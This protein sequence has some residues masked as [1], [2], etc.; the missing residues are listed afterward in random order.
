MHNKIKYILICIGTLVIIGIAFGSNI[1]KEELFQQLIEQKTLFLNYIQTNAPL[2]YILLFFLVIIFVLTPVPLAAIG[3]IIGGA[4]FGVVYG[5]LFNI[6]AT[7]IGCSIGYAIGKYLIPE[8]FYQQYRTK[9]KTI[10]N[11]FQNN[12]FLYLMILR[13]SIV[14]PFFL[15]NLIA[16]PSKKIS[17][18]SYFLST[19][20]SI[21][22]TSIIYAYGGDKIAT[23]TS[24]NQIITFETLLFLF[25]IIVFLFLIIFVQKL[26]GKKGNLTS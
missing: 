22:P 25:S 8:K 6:I 17:F 14:F 9:I 19:L 20:L 26:I 1:L 7:L 13:L 16:G 12:G 2:T 10:D 3:K 5:T 24:F 15:I 4:V 18:R 21:I 23:I 11:E